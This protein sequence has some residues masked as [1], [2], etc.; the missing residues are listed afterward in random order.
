MLKQQKIYYKMYHKCYYKVLLLFR[1]NYGNLG[2]WFLWSLVLLVVAA[3]LFMYIALL[4][5]S[6][7]PVKE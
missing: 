2:F 5:V 3:I 7:A 6:K 1:Y 4:L